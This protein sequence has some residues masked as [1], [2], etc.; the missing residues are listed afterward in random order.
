M[1]ATTAATQPASDNSA[2]QQEDHTTNATIA[3]HVRRRLI[4]NLRIRR[5]IK[6]DTGQDHGRNFIIP[7][8]ATAG[9]CARG[10]ECQEADRDQLQEEGSSIEGLVGRGVGDEI[11]LDQGHGDD[12]QDGLDEEGDEEGAAAEGAYATHD[13]GEDHGAGEEGGDGDEGFEPAPWF[14]GGLVGGAEAEEDGISCVR[15]TGIRIHAL[16]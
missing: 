12:D 8:R 3:L 13:D 11:G 1:H 16:S 7:Q 2:N 4:R 5:N 6:V 14:T 15:E 10:L 9:H